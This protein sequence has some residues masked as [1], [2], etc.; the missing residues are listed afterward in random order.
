[1]SIIDRLT[2]GDVAIV[3]E[4]S[5]M[6]IAALGDEQAP[7][8]KLMAA[9]AYVIKRKQDKGF[10]FADALNLTMDEVTEILGL[11]EDEDPKEQD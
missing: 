3:E 9:L 11:D 4:H 10:T 6:G 8:G 2:V 7:K 5:G 1:M